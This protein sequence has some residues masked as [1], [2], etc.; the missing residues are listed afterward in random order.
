MPAGKDLPEPIPLPNKLFFRIG[1]VARIVGVRPHVLRYW[2]TE[3]PVIRPAKSRTGQRVYSRHEVEIVSLIKHLLYARRYTIDGAR[4]ALREKGIEASIRE[5][6]KDTRSAGVTVARD[7]AFV[8]RGVADVLA[9]IAGKFDA[10]FPRR[11]DPAPGRHESSKAEV[12]KPS[13]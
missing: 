3:F 12:A 13:R 1:E 4:K 5:V 2:E 11:S 10:P 9:S 8:L 7:A 6:K